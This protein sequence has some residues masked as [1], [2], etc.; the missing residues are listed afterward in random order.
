MT[1]SNFPESAG[2]AT[3]GAPAGASSPDS[4]QDSEPRPAPGS[5]PNILFI[6]VDELRFPSVFP[7]GVNDV[8]EFLHRF[9]PN[10]HSLWRRG[11]KFGRHVDVDAHEQSG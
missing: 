1:Q 9:M 8:G 5:R 11:V 10:V 6:L 2:S 4:A 3:T 7:A